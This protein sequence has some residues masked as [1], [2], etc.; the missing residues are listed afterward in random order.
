MKKIVLMK[1]S[2][3]KRK[4]CTARP[5]ILFLVPELTRK[6]SERCTL[7]VESS[8]AV[9]RRFSEFDPVFTKTPPKNA[10]VL[11]SYTRTL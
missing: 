7:T 2:N 10:A 8:I 9:S 6:Q 1:I 3:F 4:I 11:R 5:G